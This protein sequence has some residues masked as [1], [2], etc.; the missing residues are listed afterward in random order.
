MTQKLRIKTALRGGLTAEQLTEALPLI[1]ALVK[2]VMGV[3]NNVAQVAMMNSRDDLVQHPAYRHRVKQAFNEAFRSFDEYEKR[4]L[5][6]S[7]VRYFHVDDMPPET[8]K[9]YGEITDREYYEYWQNVGWSVYSKHRTFI[10]ALDNKFKLS[11]QKHGV[12]HAELLCRA[13]TTEQLLNIACQRYVG[14]TKVVHKETGL[15]Q[16]KLDFIFGCFS[17]K[18]V[19]Q[20]WAKALTMIVP[21]FPLDAIEEK[22]IRDSIEQLYNIISDI[23]EMY[24]GIEKSTEDYE[25]VFRTKGEWKKQLR[26]IREDRIICYDIA[27]D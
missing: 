22:N 24:D 11:L 14:V 10:T 20:R 18:G 3:A 16:D 1:S 19:H 5:N 25:E 8:R 13:M 15:P 26:Q 6:P 9:R 27:T 21:N 2:Q 12:P 4:L 17:L 23:P 7:G